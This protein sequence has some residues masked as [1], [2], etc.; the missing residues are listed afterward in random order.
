ML[1]LLKA[2]PLPAG[3]A[4]TKLVTALPVNGR[5]Y[6]RDDLARGNFLQ[7]EQADVQYGSCQAGAVVEFPNLAQWTVDESDKE[8]VRTALGG[9]ARHIKQSY[10]YWVSKP[11]LLPL[12]VSKDNFL[13]SFLS[14][15]PPSV[16][17]SSIPIFVSDGIVDRYVPGEIVGSSGNKLMTVEACSF[18][19]DTYNESL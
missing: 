5:Y 15:Q 18:F 10:D 6:L 19:L 13:S 9:L 11:F 1:A 16:S 7:D 3:D 17:D 4:T 8:A 2:R 14:S 12:G